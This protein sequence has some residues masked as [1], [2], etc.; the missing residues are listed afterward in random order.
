M[1]KQRIPDYDVID[2]PDDTPLVLSGEPGLLNTALRMH[3]PGEKRVVVRD[4][5]IRGAPLRAGL[6]AKETPVQQI[7]PV[8]L[9]PGQTRV[10]PVQLDLD[11]HTPPGEYRCEV[12][13]AGYTRTAVI[14]VAEKVELEIAPS[15]VVVENVPGA[16]VTKQVIFSNVG[17]TT[18][19]I[20]EIG[21]VLIEDQLI[22]CRA[23]RAALAKA[24]DEVET[25]DQFNVRILQEIQN[26]IENTGFLRVRN[27]TGVVDLQP[28]EVRA[29][30]L[31]VHVPDN[32]DPRTR[33]GG[34]AGIYTADLSFSIVPVPRSRRAGKGD[35]QRKRKEKGSGQKDSD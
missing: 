8:V 31:E 21:P 9:R 3:N 20:G 13:V 6:A 23:G 14:H 5:F 16:K 27:R 33:Y 29:V 4:A 2:I 28:G 1:A 32:L 17:N 7:G 34:A 19:T 12:E 22:E 35:G 26:V 25:T 11:P 30:E 18:L 10:L 24:V 15:P